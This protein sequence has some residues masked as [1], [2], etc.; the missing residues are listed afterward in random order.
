VHGGAVAGGDFLSVKMRSPNRS[1]LCHSAA[2]S[3]AGDAA[4]TRIIEGNDQP[5]SDAC[6]SCDLC[7]M[8]V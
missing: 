6:V 2:N 5:L 1:A 3:A 7:V 4:T 8:F